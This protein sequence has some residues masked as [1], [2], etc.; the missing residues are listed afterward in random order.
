M[1]KNI[2]EAYAVED[3]LCVGGRNATSRGQEGP[4]AG[5]RASLFVVEHLHMIVP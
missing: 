3:G 5:A 2:M 4:G 1:T